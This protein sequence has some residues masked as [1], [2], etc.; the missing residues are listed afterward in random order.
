MLLPCAACW[1][2][3]DNLSAHVSRDVRTALRKTR[4]LAWYLPPNR[5]DILQ[6]VDAGAGRLLMQLYHAAQD[7]WLFDIENLELWETTMSAFKRRV[8]MTRWMGDAVEAYNGKEQYKHG[9]FRMFEKTGALMTA[10]GS[11]DSAIVPEG[12]NRST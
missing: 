4:T 2:R 12:T 8:L 6:P 1:N 3:F 5:T 11:N 7:K 9:L 10:D